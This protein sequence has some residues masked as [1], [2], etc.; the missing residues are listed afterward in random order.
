MKQMVLLAD[1]DNKLSVTY[2]RFLSPSGYR[3]QRSN[4]RRRLSPEATPRDAGGD[5][6]RSGPALGWGRRCVGLAAGG[7]PDHAR[8]SNLDLENSD[9]APWP[10]SMPGSAAA[11]FTGRRRIPAEARP[12]V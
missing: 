5:G 8:L 3:A 9:D 7:R 2:R 1:R 4:R 12:A 11:T 6:A 10:G